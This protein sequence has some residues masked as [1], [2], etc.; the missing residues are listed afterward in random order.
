MHVERKPQSSKC[1]VGPRT[2]L[3]VASYRG[4][5]ML[6]DEADVCTHASGSCSLVP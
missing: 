5:E 2:I 4:A 3:G 1:A 6:C